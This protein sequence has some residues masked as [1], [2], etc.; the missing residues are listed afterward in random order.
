[1]VSPLINVTGINPFTS[2]SE[3]STLMMA[4]AALYLLIALG[5]AIRQFGKRDL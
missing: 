3:P 1:M 5:I 2:G 4:Y